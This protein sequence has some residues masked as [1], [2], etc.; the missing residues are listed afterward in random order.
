MNKGYVLP[1]L[2]TQVQPEPSASIQRQLLAPGGR[3]QRLTRMLEAWR[4]C[5]PEH[6]IGCVSQN[7][8]Q[9]G[10]LVYGAKDYHLRNPS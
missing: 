10:T 3:S 1:P 5:M 2:D 6:K 4:V 8:Y 7:M 9:N